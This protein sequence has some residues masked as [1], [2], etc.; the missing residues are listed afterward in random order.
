LRNINPD[1]DSIFK[2]DHARVL[3]TLVRLIG[4]LDLAE[5]ALQE[6]MF[7]AVLQ[8]PQDGF[9]SNPA[10]WL[11]STARYKAIDALRKSRSALAYDAVRTLEAWSTDSYA[12]GDTIQ[13]DELKL[14]CMCCHPVLS[15]EQRCALA[16]REV[17][18]LTTAEAA[19]ADLLPVSTMAQRLV[20]A[21]AALR[22]HLV[23]LDEPE[24][25]DLTKRMAAVLQTVYLLFNEGYLASSGPELTRP[26]LSSE[27]IRLGRI[28]TRVSP[29]SDTYGLLALMLFN[30]ARRP[31]RQSK[32]GEILLLEDQDRSLW[33]HELIREARSALMRAHSCQPAGTYVL[34]AEMAKTHMDSPDASRVDWHKIVRLYNALIMLAPSPVAELN[35]AAAVSF[36][37]GPDAA[38]TL[39]TQ[40]EKDGRLAGYSYLYSTRADLHR[41]LGNY[42]EAILNYKLALENTQSQP[43]ARFLLARIEAIEAMQRGS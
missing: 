2:Q 37:D 29:G 3:A 43:E 8:W 1:L 27:A 13:D 6:A 24:A 17:C 31:A 20:R 35:R 18:G 33:S 4:S 34:L 26:A 39:L 25:N 16:L 14:I 19:K 7:A 41:R 40:L 10:A 38:L 32:T 15:S 30:E 22:K 42:A 36:A 28:L 11:V 21:K 9:P 23:T 5:D 12:Y